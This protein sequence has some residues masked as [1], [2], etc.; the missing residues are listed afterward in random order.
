ML[1][2][3]WTAHAKSLVH[4]EHFYSKGLD[5]LL[6]IIAVS[7]LATAKARR[8]Y[9]ISFADDG[10]Q[11]LTALIST[12]SYPSGRRDSSPYTTDMSPG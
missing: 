5:Q 7:G 10:E 12:T 3:L 2:F 11:K 8:P 9:Y 4:R 1:G 6:M